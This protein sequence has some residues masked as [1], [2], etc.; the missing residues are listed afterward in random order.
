MKGSHRDHSGQS[1][2]EYQKLRISLAFNEIKTRIDQK[3]LYH[4]LLAHY[5]EYRLCE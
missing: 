2:D 5:L 1:I 4:Q 3:G